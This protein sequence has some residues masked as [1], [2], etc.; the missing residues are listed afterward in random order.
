MTRAGQ[1]RE[2]R[3]VKLEAAVS[4]LSSKSHKTTECIKSVICFRLFKAL[5]VW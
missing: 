1:K 3:E 5:N 4:E 2:V